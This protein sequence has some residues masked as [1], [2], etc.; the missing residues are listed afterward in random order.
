MRAET[1]L[2]SETPLLSVQGL[3]VTFDGFTAVS[4]LSFDLYEGQTLAIVG[5]SGSGKSVTALSI[6]RL[7]TFG[8]RAKIAEGQIFF[9]QPDGSTIDLVQADEAELR[10]IRG[11]Q[12]SMIFQEPLTSL[13]PVYTAGNQVVEAI[14]LH[15]DVTKAEAYQ[16]AFEVFERVRIP[17]PKKRLKEYPHQMSGG[18]RQRVMIAMA[19]SC[20]PTVLIADEPTTALDVTIQAQ[21]LGLMRALQD[22]TGAAVIMITHDMGVVAEVADDIVVMRNSKLVETGNVFDIFEKPTAPYTKALL[23]S[24]PRLGSMTGKSQPERFDLVDMDA[25]V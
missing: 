13:N 2:R 19:L 14:R 7:V 25:P 1:P 12:I 5:E 21:I 24:I 16:R 11:N 8:T 20:D 15:Q 23:A 3:T 9:R 17:E 22:E 10:K 18:M 4:E 6:M